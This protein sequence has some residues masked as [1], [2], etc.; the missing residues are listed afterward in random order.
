[1]VNKFLVKMLICST[2][3]LATNETCVQE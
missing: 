1:M 3:R 2:L